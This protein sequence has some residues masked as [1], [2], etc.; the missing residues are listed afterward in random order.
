M[1]V[2]ADSGCAPYGLASQP[3]EYKSSQPSEGRDVPESN[4]G[5]DGVSIV[6]TEVQI[7]KYGDLLCEGVALAFYLWVK[8]NG[9]SY[10]ESRGEWFNG[11]VRLTHEQVFSMFS[12]SCQN[13]T[14]VEASENTSGIA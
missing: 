1:M 13:V 5:Q 11:L 4:I 12:Q 14:H 2:N 8:Q 6:T 3:N 10:S 9:W 7:E